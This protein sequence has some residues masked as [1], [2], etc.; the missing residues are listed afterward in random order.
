MA[1]A[2][3][4]NY[5]NVLRQ[6]GIKGKSQLMSALPYATSA[7][8]PGFFLSDS[9]VP[10]HVLSLSLYWL[11]HLSHGATRTSIASG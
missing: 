9:P 11:A 2:S 7:R 5:C 10:L 3:I 8:L 1:M 6:T 4:N